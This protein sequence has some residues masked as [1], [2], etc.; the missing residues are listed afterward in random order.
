[1]PRAARLAFSAAAL[2]ALAFIG[3]QAYLDVRNVPFQ[4]EFATVLDFLLRFR[5]TK[6][7]TD[8]IGLLFHQENEHR[9]VT[10][11]LIF[12]AMRGLTGGVNF[13]T[14][15]VL[16]DLFIAGAIGVIA[17]QLREPVLRL[18]MGVVMTL[19][20][21]QM[22]HFENLFLSYSSVDHF[23]IV[24][25][26]AASLALLN[27][28]SVW[29]DIGG[30]LFSALACFT[31]AH[32]LALFPAGLL[33]LL[34][35]RRW[36]SAAAWLAV[37]AVCCGA[38]LFGLAGYTR[39]L[40]AFHSAAGWGAFA[41]FWL[42][43]MGGVPTL[44]SALYAPLFGLGALGI[45]G[46]LV[47]RGAWRREAYLSALVVSAL[48]ATF[49]IAYGRFGFADLPPTS[50]RYM[51]QS[52]LLWSVLSLLVLKELPERFF[53]L[54]A[55]GLVLLAAGLSVA[56][57]FRFKPIA[58]VMVARRQAVSRHYWRTGSLAGAPYSIYP[59]T[60]VADRLLAD[61]KKSGL[62]AIQPGVSQ[63]SE[64]AEPV[65]QRNL[66]HCIDELTVG[67][68]CVFVLGWV[69]PPLGRKMAYQPYLVLQCG[70]RKYVF[71]GERVYR[72]DVAKVHAMAYASECGF[73]FAV[74]RTALPKAKMT[75]SLA[76]VGWDG[77]LLS[78]IVGNFTN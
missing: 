63:Q 5:D 71:R 37:G 53:A 57:D 26:G 28:G 20:V 8:F 11:R 55:T 24:L 23:H 78:R 73:R 10:S 9:I 6:T 75:L 58:D 39:P 43:I 74:P 18:I 15:A 52:A 7:W 17:W 77:T 12:L 62:Y 68:E 64:V 54:G 67:P 16:G 65:Q 44:G 35:Q 51:V 50:S 21:F 29:G 60:V 48:V 66:D 33:I 72:P 42:S 25:L 59:D 2:G 14:V 56:A 22:Q 34:L 69:L 4:D 70:E 40:V 61:A 3:W 19:L 46:W 1:V 27:R 31:L 49:L 41:H 30:M 13:V 38:F 36:V 76:L 32:G 45:A 47:F